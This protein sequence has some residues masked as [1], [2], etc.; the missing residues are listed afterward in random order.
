MMVMEMMMRGRRGLC[1][2]AGVRRSWKE[3]VRKKTNKPQS[4][5]Q[6]G[7]SHVM[8]AP[9]KPNSQLQ[10]RAKVSGVLPHPL[11]CPWVG[12]SPHC[13]TLGLPASFYI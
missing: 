13:L 11:L 7:G 8:E 12:S 5:G 1:N 4:S 3:P 6:L 9:R 10:V 2:R